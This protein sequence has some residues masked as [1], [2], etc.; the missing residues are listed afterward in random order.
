MAGLAI[1]VGQL[2]QEYG[3]E[4]LGVIVLIAGGMQLFAAWLQL[5]QWFRAVSPAVIQGMLAGIGVLIFAAQFHAM[6]DD[7]APGTGP[8][9]GGII[10][11]ATIQQAV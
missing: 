8:E 7:Q 2:I 1:I 5:G 6:V 9:F 10:N 3:Y 4:R 11:L